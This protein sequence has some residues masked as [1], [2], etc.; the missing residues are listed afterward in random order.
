MKQTAGVTDMNRAS[1]AVPLCV[2]LDGTL[3]RTDVLVESF[4]ALVKRSPLRAA[5]AVLGLRRGRASFKQEIA[6]QIDLDAATLPYDEE[7]VAYLR[8]ERAGGRRIVLTTATNE[9]YARQIAAHVGLFDE[10]LASDAGTNLSG[11]RK[12]GRLRERFGTGGFDYAGN[13]HA[14]LKIW[15]AA[16][17]AVLVRPE[18][19][20]ETR[21]ARS[22]RIARVFRARGA[23]AK[24]LL[25]AIRVHQWLKNLLLFVPLIAAHRITDV[26]LLATAVIAF[27]SFS[28]CAS[29]AY[30]VNDLLDLKADRHH[31]RKR[32][33]PFAAGTIPVDQGL[34]LSALLLAGGLALAAFVSAAFLGTVVL[35]YFLTLAYSLSIKNRVLADILLLAGLY[36]LRI[37]AGGVAVQVVPSFWLLAFSMFLFLSLAMVK[38]YSEI[39]GLRDTDQTMTIGRGYR[40]T[41]LPTLM[42]LGAA[43]A[44]TSVLILAL[45][46]DT[47]SL[48]YQQPM[49]LWGL[50]PLMLYWVSRLWVGAGRGKID[51]DPLVFALRDGVSRWIAVAAAVILWL[52]T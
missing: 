11:A 32:F 25:R 29:S 50:P 51:D 20:V 17:Q 38:R 35:Y 39:A 42:S 30:V 10:V 46:I 28:L 13:S 7:V 3:I 33:R 43:S 37:V 16:R 36:T 4:L 31:P 23:G 40:L 24:D 1:D 14:D 34:G 45:Y 26:G 52:A 6:D 2:D 5:R 48:L 47:D 12:L 9:K 21:A 8:E 18:C 19:G 27:F 44:Y 49:Y 41:D 22:S 15:P